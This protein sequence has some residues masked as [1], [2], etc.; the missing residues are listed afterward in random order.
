M[1]FF[2]TMDGCFK[3]VACGWAFAPAGPQGMYCSLVI[4]GLSIAGRGGDLS[5]T[6]VR[7]LVSDRLAAHAG[8]LKACPSVMRSC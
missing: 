6:D 8:L 7:T 1:S 5:G 2:D 3:S 4:T